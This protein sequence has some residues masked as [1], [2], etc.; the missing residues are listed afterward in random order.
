[1]AASFRGLLLEKDDGQLKARIADNL[2]DADLMDGDVTVA[3]SHSTINYK[4]GLAM[5]GAAPIVRRWPM[6]PGIDLAGTVES[7]EHPDFKPGDRVLQNGWGLSETHLGGYATRARLQGAHLIPI[8]EV[9]T[10]AQ[11]M[12]IGTAGYT[13]MLAIL[14]LERHGVKPGGGPV[15]VTGAAG[16]VGSVATAILAKLGYEVTAST[17]RP[18]EA[19]YLKSLGA[20]VIV[21]RAELGNPAPPI[22]KERWQ[23]VVDSVGS[24]TLANAL[25]HTSYLGCVAACGL[26][27]GSDLPATVLPFLLRGV[28]LVGIDSVQAPRPIRLEAWSR[29]AHDL[30]TKKL[31]AMTRTVSLD[32]ASKMGPEILQG[33]VRGRIVVD[34]NA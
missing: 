25:A 26:A 8:P 23:G 21:P 10:A 2:T 14:A 20:S 5:T 27:Q 19:D 18:E 16:G 1:M 34:V 9:F 28:T 12:A 29:L 7:S 17:G 33:K 22:G 13:A 24:H 30:D 4:D 31:D 15:L 3:V 11:A 6:I 32:E